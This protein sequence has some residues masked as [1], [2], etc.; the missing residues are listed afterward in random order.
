MK[1]KFRR[2]SSI[3]MMFVM[4]LSTMPTVFADSSGNIADQCDSVNTYIYDANKNKLTAGEDGFIKVKEGESYY[5]DYTFFSADPIKEGRY[6][7]S[8]YA[9]GLSISNEIQ[10]GDFRV[11]DGTI[12]TTWMVCGNEIIFDFLYGCQRYKNVTGTVELGCCFSGKGREIDFD[13]GVKVKVVGDNTVTVHKTEAGSENPIEGAV[14][15]F[16]TSDGTLLETQTTGADGNLKFSTSDQVAF[17]EHTGYYIAEITAPEGYEVSDE[18]NY[19]YFCYSHGGCSECDGMDAGYASLGYDEVMNL[20]DEKIIPKGDL[21]VSKSVS[22]DAADVDKEFNF[23]VVLSDDSINGTYSD[24]TFENGEASFTLKDGESMT[25]VGLLADVTYKVTEAE[26]NEDGYVTT[27]ENEEGTIIADT[28]TEVNFVNTKDA[29]PTPSPT[30]TPT[31]EP[32]A[33]PTVTP[34]A[35]PTV[36]PTATPTV[37]PTA[38]PTATTPTATPTV[39]NAPD[40]TTP[41]TGDTM[42]LKLWLSILCISATGVIVVLVVLKRK[43][44]NN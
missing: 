2:V 20:S 11:Y 26:A 23:T 17:E 44:H 21:K 8:I 24:M 9:E 36:A 34:T 10:N 16:Y 7:Y 41:K 40:G 19:F 29:T 38:T 31:V 28:T 43:G 15:G 33:T 42:N 12:I 13:G 18:K 22:G 32:T 25:A 3:L 39:T 4:L 30:A 5:I 6:T 1:V 27:S 35:T 37:S 14:Y